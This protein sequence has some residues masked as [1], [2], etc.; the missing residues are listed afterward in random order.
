VV[1][2]SIEQ[3]MDLFESAP[4]S[5]A[6]TSLNR[7]LSLENW[8]QGEVSVVS[9]V[10]NRRASVYLNPLRHTVKI[11]IY[12]PDLIVSLA[13]GDVL[14]VVADVKPHGVKAMT[15]EVSGSTNRTRLSLRLRPDIELRFDST[16]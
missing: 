9:A 3:L 6:E 1:V 14:A 8:P 7:F 10:A 13:V 11:E 2:P 16:G 15:V 4:V 5:I 12:A